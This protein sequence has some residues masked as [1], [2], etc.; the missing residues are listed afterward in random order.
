MFSA[1]DKSRDVA[2]KDLYRALGRMVHL[3]TT[4]SERIEEIKRWADTRAVQANA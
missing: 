3:S 1:F 4:M 2:M